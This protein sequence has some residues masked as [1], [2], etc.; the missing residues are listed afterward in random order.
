M[1][2]KRKIVEI[3]AARD[4]VRQ[5]TNTLNPSQAGLAIELAFTMQEGCASLMAMTLAARVIETFRDRSDDELALMIHGFCSF[6]EAFKR[7]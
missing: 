2:D 1:A 5:P 4:N 3:A 7:D 6:A